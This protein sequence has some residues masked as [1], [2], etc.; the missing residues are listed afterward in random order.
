MY[1]YIYIYVHYILFFFNMK[2][3]WR[4]KNTQK[5]TKIFFG[6]GFLYA[7]LLLVKVGL[8]KP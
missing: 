8:L 7:V 2:I 5:D 6:L 3:L 4:E 1:I